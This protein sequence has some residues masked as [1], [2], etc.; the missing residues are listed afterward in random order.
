M[1]ALQ[2]AMSLSLKNLTNALRK[3]DDWQ[4]LGIQLEI[5]YHELQKV[6]KVHSTIE[7]RKYAVLQLWLDRDTKASWEKLH[8]ALSEMK[9]NRVADK[10]KRKY[11]MPLSTQLENPH[12]LVLPV[13][14]ESVNDTTT[15]PLS[16]L[17]TNQPCQN[18]IAQSQSGNTT[19]DLD[20][21]STPQSK[22]IQITQSGSV[23]ITDRPSVPSTDQLEQPEQAITKRVRNIQL[24]IAALEAMYDDLVARAGLSL[25]KKQALSPEFVIEFR[26]SVAVLPTSLKYQHK[27]F[28]EHHSSQ[29]ARATTVEEIFSIL[30]RYCNFLNCGLLTYLISKFGDEELKKQLSTYTT[31]LQ[32]FRSRTMLTDFVRTCTGKQNIVPELASLKTKMGSEWEHCTLEDAEEFRKFMANSSSLAD[33][34]FHFEEIATGS[35]YL[36][37]SIPNHATDFIAS[38]MNFEFLQHHH[39]EEVAIDNVDLEEYKRQHYIYP[40]RQFNAISQV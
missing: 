17:P 14:A 27:Y 1:K 29:I 8:S 15:D 19:L 18:L 16:T 28:L 23:P 26:F 7:E 11:Q 22:Q 32:A 4:G 30:N 38:A 37:W 13:T 5:D 24:E 20:I 21:P 31:A 35:I 6:A 3:V 25:S 12:P 34:V 33:Y 39:I 2:K 40:G 36:S 10:V 9:L